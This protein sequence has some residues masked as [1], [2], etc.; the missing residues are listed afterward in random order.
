MEFTL[1][2]LGMLVFLILEACQL[3]LILKLQQ[4]SEELWCLVLELQKKARG[5]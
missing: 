3:V 5:E 1:I 2:A 4:D